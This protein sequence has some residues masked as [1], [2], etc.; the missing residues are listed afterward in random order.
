MIDKNI[1]IIYNTNNLR[2]KMK[3]IFVLIIVLSGV[4]SAEMSTEE[5]AKASQNPLTAMY[6]LPIQNNTY[7]GNEVKNIANIQPVLPFDVSDNWTLVTRTIL[8]VVY[9]ETS[10]GADDWGLG[11]T[12][13]TGFF[14]PKKTSTS[15][16]VWGVGP[17]IL[18]PTSTDDVSMG[19][20]EWG[21]GVSAIVLS[22]NGNWVYGGLISNVWSFTGDNSVNSMTFQPFVNYNLGDGLFLASVPI[23]TANWKAE[24]S[25][26]TW[27]VP[28]GLGVGKAMKMGNVPFTAQIHAYYNVERPDANSEDW[29]MRI[30]VQWLFPR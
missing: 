14:T 1:I 18:I 8:P 15:G 9:N 27:T 12:T 21:A 25:S 2:N 20:G 4:L 11:D 29:Q 10:F 19:I 26:N 7:F 30:Q 16:I 17:T 22:M 13:M 6:S 28:L 24:E 3:K 5:I 23:I